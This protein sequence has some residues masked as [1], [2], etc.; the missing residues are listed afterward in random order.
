MAGTFFFNVWDQVHGLVHSRQAFYHWTTFKTLKCLFG[1][2]NI[3]KWE[4]VRWLNVKNTYCSCRGPEVAPRYSWWLTSVY[5]SSSIPLVHTHKHTRERNTQF[6]RNT[7]L[8]NNLKCPIETNKGEQNS[9][10]DADLKSYTEF[11]SWNQLRHQKSPT[12]TSP[13]SW[14]AMIYSACRTAFCATCKFIYSLSWR[15]R[16]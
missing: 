10:A 5:N 12:G 2:F 13:S 9:P 3:L 8:K 14:H 6:K 7:Q 1:W 11:I 15:C 16:A 4:L